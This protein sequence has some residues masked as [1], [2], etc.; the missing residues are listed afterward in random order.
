M[1]QKLLLD[2]MLQVFGKP[3]NTCNNCILLYAWHGMKLLLILAGS[4]NV[5]LDCDVVKI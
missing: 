5:H 1:H 4:A 3:D 2:S